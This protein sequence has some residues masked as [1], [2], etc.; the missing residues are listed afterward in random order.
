MSLAAVTS[1][2]QDFFELTARGT[3]SSHVDTQ[4]PPAQITKK[5]AVFF[6]ER[7]PSAYDSTLSEISSV[8]LA[9]FDGV[10][11]RRYY[12]EGDI[13]ALVGAAVEDAVKICNSM[14][15]K[16]WLDAPPLISRR[17]SSLFTN[18]LDH[19]VVID[20]LTGNPVLVVED[21]KPHDRVGTSATVHGQITPFFATT[22]ASGH[23]HPLG[24]V[25][26]FTDSWVYYLDTP[27]CLGRAR[28][29][30]RFSEE[31]LREYIRAIAPESA[32]PEGSPIK[33]RKTVPED[34]NDTAAAMESV[35]EQDRTLCQSISFGPHE[36]VLRLCNAIFCNLQDISGN[37][38][39][40]EIPKRLFSHDVLEV[41]QGG[42]RW[43][44]LTTKSDG[45]PLKKPAR[46]RCQNYYLL[47][48][49]GTGRTSKAFRAVS[50]E[51]KQCVIKIYVR[52]YDESNNFQLIP[53]R[54][55]EAAAKESVTRE[56][57][58]YHKLYP[59]LKDYVWKQKLNKHHCVILPFFDPID[60]ADRHNPDVQNEILDV[61]KTRFVLRPTRRWRG[62]HPISYRFA[63]G[64][65]L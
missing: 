10:E 42:Y 32:K 51:G 62:I 54:Q 17:E 38:V 4:H 26:T 11:E 6:W 44:F 56:V 28:D 43:C 33:I 14:L 64:D 57:H 31:K 45:K 52:K 3:T 16:T 59:E 5:N 23:P 63:D 35:V 27:E 21:K 48:L 61:L 15:K 8:L 22:R 34:E 9:M 40:H 13:Q 53:Q 29:N 50:K 46:I 2:T 19:T 39:I 37:S 55:Y 58:H 18:K 41:T 1:K 24:I 7:I 49:L 25:T 12:T 20:E 30:D 65:R 60:E 36:L 47:S